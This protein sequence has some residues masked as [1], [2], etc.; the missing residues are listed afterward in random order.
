[1]TY[2]KNKE[3][4]KGNKVVLVRQNQQDHVLRVNKENQELTPVI[5]I[6]RRQP[7]WDKV[8]I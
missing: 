7:S 3:V 6:R 2:K 4:S 8:T 1:M 5:Q